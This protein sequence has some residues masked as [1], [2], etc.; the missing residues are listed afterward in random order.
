MELLTGAYSLTIPLLVLSRGLQ[1][2][3]VYSL[4]SV[5]VCRFRS[6]WG[7]LRADIHARQQVSS[8]ASRWG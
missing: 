8:P 5:G 6:F 1:I 4:G 2:R 7:R 3:D